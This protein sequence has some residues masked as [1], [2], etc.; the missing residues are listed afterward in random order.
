MLNLQKTNNKKRFTPRLSLRHEVSAW[1]HTQTR[2]R[3]STK[4][5]YALC[6]LPSTA[7][8]VTETEETSA[9]SGSVSVDFSTGVGDSIT[10]CSLVEAGGTCSPSH[11]VKNRV[12]VSATKTS[13]VARA[14]PPLTFRHCGVGWCFY[15]CFVICYMNVRWPLTHW[16]DELLLRLHNMCT[17]I[18]HQRLSGPVR[19]G[20]DDG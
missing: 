18:C 7:G 8:S 13:N 17:Y 16:F 19:R 10:A 14:A 5:V 1:Y 12:Y 15:F 9:S 4:W 6:P 3:T 2:R 11:G 20:E